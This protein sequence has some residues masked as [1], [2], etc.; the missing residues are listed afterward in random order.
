MPMF[1]PILE[2]EATGKVKEVFEEIKSEDWS[3][4]GN[5]LG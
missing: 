1:K 4:G 3:I 5:L 2:N